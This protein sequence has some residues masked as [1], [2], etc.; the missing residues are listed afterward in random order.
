MAEPSSASRGDVGTPDLP[1]LECQRELFT[2]PEGVHYLNCA[3][4]GPLPLASQQRGVEGIQ[5]RALPTG[6]TAPDFFK[7]S[8]ELRRLFARSIGAGDARRV[9]LL[10]SVSYGI[11]IAAR[12]LPCE[13]GQNIV[14]AAE[15]FPSNVYAWRRLARDTGAELRT[16]ASPVSAPPRSPAW[17]DA[18]LSAIDRATCIVALPQVHWTDGTRFDLGRIARRARE[19][20]AAVVIDGTQTIGAMDF[21]LDRIQPDAVVCAAYKW[22]LG[23]Y[24]LAFGW[25][26]P[27]LDDGVPLEETWIA[28]AGSENFQGLVD[29][30]DE[31]QPG[32]SRYDVG[33]RSNFVLV[34]MALASLSLVLEWGPARIQRYCAELFAGAVEEAADLGYAVEPPEGRGAHIFGLRVPAG[35]ELNALNEA[36]KAR[37]VFASLRGSALRVSPNVYNDE[38]DAAALIGALRAASSGVAVR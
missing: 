6:L 11:A 1:A 36:L 15:Q 12:N 16:V 13:A 18:L 17:N 31:Y 26:G 9:A 7:D 23:P 4:M 8:D 37:N 25:F 3:Y 32:A 35:M 29:Y 38:R 14:V 2:I 22:L 28:R 5:R 20:G 10:P 30:R 21:E 24:S 19:V 34:P 27:R 33:E